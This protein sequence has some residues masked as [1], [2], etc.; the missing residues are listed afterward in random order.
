MPRQESR[1]SRSHAHGW[2]AHPCGGCRSPSRT[3]RIGFSEWQV[4]LEKQDE[5]RQTRAHG[6]GRG[7]HAFRA[8][9]VGVWHGKSWSIVSFSEGRKLFRKQ[10]HL[11]QHAAKHPL[12]T[13]ARAAR[14]ARSRRGHGASRGPA[15]NQTM[16]LLPQ[17]GFVHWGTIRFEQAHGRNY[18]R[19]VSWSRPE[20]R[21]S[22]AAEAFP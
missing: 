19:S 12:H 10:G 21:Y 4:R 2:H 3:R 9:V 14:A 17:R 20:A 7:A 16:L 15:R 11:F 5:W 8:A 6:N 22:K 18:L 1:D 13:N